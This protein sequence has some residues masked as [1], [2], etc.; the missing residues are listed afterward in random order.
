MVI[1]ELPDVPDDADVLLV[2][3]GTRTRPYNNRGEVI[4]DGFELR[5]GDRIVFDD[6][7]DTPWDSATA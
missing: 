2:A 3:W 7:Y 1:V 5:E 4:K 6:M